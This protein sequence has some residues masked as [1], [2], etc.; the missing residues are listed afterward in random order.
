M[1]N[2][3]EAEK[4]YNKALDL[5]EDNKIDE[6]LDLLIKADKLNPDSLEIKETLAI[7]YNIK[8]DLDKAFP[9]YEDI[10][11]KYPDYIYPYVNYINILIA[12]EQTEKA[13]DI[14]EK[15]E[16]LIDNELKNNP[17]NHDLYIIAS[18]IYYQMEFV[19][20]A[21][22]LLYRGILETGF[23]ADFY[24]ELIIY[25]YELGIYEE[26]IKLAKE[27]LKKVKKDPTVYL[28]LGLSLQK[29]NYLNE[30]LKYLEISK[31]LDPEQPEL[32]TLV[33][34]INEIIEYRGDTIEEL[35]QKSK[36]GKKYSGTVKW[37]DEE[38]G[39]GAI[40]SDKFDDEIFI[41]Y[42]AIQMEGFQTIGENSNVTF[43][44][45]KS[46]KGLIA[47]YVWLSDSPVNKRFTGK[48]TLFDKKN[49][50]GNI[51]S[52]EAGEIFF[53]YSAIIDNLIKILE[54]DDFVEFSIFSVEGY[55]QAYNIK[56]ISPLPEKKPAIMS[57]NK[58]FTGKLKWYDASVG[59]GIIEADNGVEVI[60]QK[61]SIPSVHLSKIKPGISLTFNI[62]E[63]EAITGEKIPRAINIVFNF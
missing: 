3:K 52:E 33:E 20:E 42:T 19:D 12:R 23:D 45:K 16:E 48:I 62:D 5:V 47:T 46:S 40:K 28:Y 38:K 4:L 58:N 10:I 8:G 57:D 31:K 41:H 37:F 27:A 54:K 29:M 13:Y 11:K 22:M 63:V 51:S 14:F 35:I 2:I 36:P 25:Y 32:E 34:K 61:S 56:K 43:C 18:S 39:I 49:G 17:K 9:I 24:R 53:H 50:M 15:A 30:S 21:I 26:A 1:K 7:L 6:A 44:V 55:T 59:Y 60:I